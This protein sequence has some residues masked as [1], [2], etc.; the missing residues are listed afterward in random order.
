[1][2]SSRQFR[3]LLMVLFASVSLLASAGS[4]WFGL[5]ISVDGSG[6]FWNP[7]VT[8]ITIAEVVPDSPAAR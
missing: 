1:M 8:S 3:W 6:V 2:K 7:T 4:G 5:A